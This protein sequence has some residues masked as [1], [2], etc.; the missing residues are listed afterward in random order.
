METN[1]IVSKRSKA[2]LLF[3]LFILNVIIRIPSIPHEKGIDSFFLHL[4]ASSLSVYGE[5]TWWIN[6]FSI[7]GFFPFSYASATPF[8]L[9][10]I[11]Q[12][13]DVSMEQSILLYC[14]L[15][16]LFSMF[17]MYLFA[18]ALYNNF[19]FK[20][21]ASMSFSLSQGILLYTTW[22]VGGR[23]VYLIFVP[24]FLYLLLTNKE[25][26]PL[27]T[28]NHEQKN[29]SAFSS[30]T[31][32][33]LSFSKLIN[34]SWTQSNKVWNLK[35]GILLFILFLFLF[36]TH[37]YAF[38]A[39]PLLISYL[40][41]NISKKTDLKRISKHS[42]HVYIILLIISLIFPFFGGL[43]I[44]G[45]SRYAWILDAAITTSRWIGPLI[46]FTVGG[47]VSTLLKK[48]KSFGDWFILLSLLF[49]I[50]MLYSQIYGKFLIIPLVIIF[51]SKAF[52]NIINL[53]VKSKT[54][55]QAFLIFILLF[56]VLFSSFFNHFRTSESG[57]YWYMSDET[58]SGGLWAKS[59]IPE[60][61][62]ALA[63]AGTDGVDSL[64]CR[65]FSS[66]AEE[67][68]IIATEGATNL[69]FGLVDPNNIQYISNSFSSKEFYFEGPFVS[70]NEQSLL[71]STNWILSEEDINRTKIIDML[72]NQSIPYVLEG[73]NDNYS[74][75]PS[76]DNTKDRVYDSGSFKI[77]RF[78]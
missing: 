24:L 10:G 62:H 15:L 70:Q 34:N 16:G 28:E 59:Y 76:V 17:S 69:A 20:Y 9:S 57:S 43:F 41:L 63:P 13:A 4:L 71:G 52:M 6:K 3:L 44:E 31:L 60:G 30:N 18:G 26:C 14:V 2:I 1:Q 53:D 49:F 58:N 61:S 78:D 66:V 75:F 5:A 67:H 68:F 73:V 39:I 12:V 64:L 48:Q 51:I 19:F 25:S 77:H 74:I 32:G 21:I 40:F 35:K 37:H 38:F 7:F 72:H 65:R 27:V 22:E 29:I 42:V 46:L 33:A 36:A 11:Q 56:T 47:L 55:L 45:G 50:P 8:T 54:S 23:G